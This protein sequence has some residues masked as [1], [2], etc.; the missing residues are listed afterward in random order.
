MKKHHFLPLCLVFLLS[1]HFAEAQVRFGVKAGVNSASLHLKG[2]DFDPLTRFQGGLVADIPVV[3]HFAIQPALLYSAKGHSV[4]SEERDQSGIPTGREFTFEAKLNYLEIPVLALYK[5]EL[6]KGLKFFGGLGPYLGIGI[7]GRFTG[8]TPG[9]KD[10]LISFDKSK[11][12]T[13]TYERF[14]MGLSAAVGLEYRSL[15]LGL[16]YNYGLRPVPMPSDAYNRTLGLT[17]GYFFGK[18]K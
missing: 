5:N 4:N 16:N 12:G 18:G 13:Q 1:A 9:F 11:S 17:A 8:N 3:S 14:D 15:M 2:V 6:G 7:N 10:Q